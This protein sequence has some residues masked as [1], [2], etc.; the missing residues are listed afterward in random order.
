MSEAGPNSRRWGF[1]AVLALGAAIGVA[2]AGPAAAQQI[3]TLNDALALTYATNPAL[4]AARAQLRVVDENVP[5]A[6]AGWRPTVTITANAGYADS[7]SLQYIRPTA[8]TRGR[9]VE[10]DS[11]RG[12]NT[13]ALT[14]TQP[15]FRGGATVSTVNFRENQVLA[16]RATLIGAEQTAFGS[17]VE[18]YVGVIQSQQVLALTINNEQVLSRQLQATRERFRVG[19]ITRTDVAQAEAALAGATANRQTAE[20]DVQVA[21]AR[22]QQVIGEPA[23][24]R[25]VEPQ[26]LRLPTRT[27]DEA[28]G[29][30]GSNNPSVVAAMFTDAAARDN[31]DV[32]YAR[33]MPNLSLQGSLSRNEDV[34]TKDL[35]TKVAQ[36]LMVLSVP[37]Y[38]GG[39]EYA[40]IRQARQD[41]QRTRQQVDDARRQAIQQVTEA[42]NRYASARA[43]IESTRQQIRSNEIALEGVQREAI[44]GSRTTL[45]VLN[46]EQRLLNSRVT[47]VRNLGSLITA[48]YGVAAAGGR[49]TARD[50][51]LNVPLYD[52]TAYYKA[53]RNRLIGTGDQATNQPGR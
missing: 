48:S 27:L 37:L 7:T 43:T 34:Q 6:L 41:Q 21:R 16:Q 17:A 38:Q 5:Q 51:N 15:L 25:L 19:E 9:T 45:D 35:T 42:W 49:L 28:R 2:L 20:G 36:I 47:L 24:E 1:R 14:V 26:P 4:L 44:V 30:A 23:P 22:F 3:R 39:A 29:L 52:E 18:A 8:I 13:Q 10:T 32:Q 31:F 12:T 46:E 53:V 40:A 33:L 50:L 11:F